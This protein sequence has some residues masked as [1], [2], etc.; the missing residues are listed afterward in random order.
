MKLYHVVPQETAFRILLEGFWDAEAPD[1]HQE[2]VWLT[3]RPMDANDG[4]PADWNSVLEIDL[5]LSQDDLSH[6]RCTAETESGE[7][8]T[9]GWLIPAAIVNSRSTA[10]LVEQGELSEPE[11]QAAIQ[12][13]EAHLR[14][15]GMIGEQ[16]EEAMRE[17]EGYLRRW[18]PAE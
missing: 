6:W 10:R 8:L 14:Q 3:S 2:G 7:I 12:R 4:L 9:L 5:D 11:V 17:F 13:H 15:R 1:F 16:L 18:E